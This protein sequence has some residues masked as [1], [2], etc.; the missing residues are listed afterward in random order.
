MFFVLTIFAPM[1]R[2]LRIDSVKGILLILVILGHVIEVSDNSSFSQ[3]LYDFIYLF[4]MPLF[5]YISGSLTKRKDDFKAF[6]SG[7]AYILIPYVI[8]QSVHVAA[9]LLQGE[10]FSMRHIVIPCWTLW[11][12]L[13]LA[14]WK[15]G[16]Q[17]FA[18]ILNKYPL[19]ILAVSIILCLLCGGIPHGRVLS[20][21]RTFHFLPFFLLGY[22]HGRGLIPCISFRKPTSII[23][24]GIVAI[25][26]ALGL[27]PDDV[28][29]I[30][31][32]SMGYGTDR[33]FAKSFLMLCSFAMTFSF[34]SLVQENRILA[35][36]GRD[37]LVYYMYHSLIIMYVLT[38]AIHR[39][40]LPHDCIAFSLTY[41]LGILG[42]IS[43]ARRFRPITFLASPLKR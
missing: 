34:F 20:I 16:V 39:F 14:Y 38:P 12:L 13:S 22:Y 41:T 6:L 3:K 19:P 15:T 30:L 18:N 24:I 25:I 31:Y 26:V 33:I 27:L 8:F 10:S 17:V 42:L 1:K 23:I 32:G 36:V 4:H 28:R 35:S 29:W 43:V 37:S 21:Q 2:D 5:I 7:L 40:H 11:Y 9:L